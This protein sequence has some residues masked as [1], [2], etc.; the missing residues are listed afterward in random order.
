MNNI[1]LKQLLRDRKEAGLP[2]SCTPPSLSP[3]TIR[4]KR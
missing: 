1:V 3:S 2:R 4:A